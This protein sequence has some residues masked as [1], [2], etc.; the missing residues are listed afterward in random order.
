MKKNK[1]IAFSLLVGLSSFLYAGFSQS[2]NFTTSVDT[3]CGVIIKST[4]SIAFRDEEPKHMGEFRII[5]NIDKRKDVLLKIK[6]IKKSSNIK[7]VNN[8]DIYVYIDRFK[9]IRIKELQNRGIKLKTSNHKMYIYIDKQ[10]D[11]I[12]KGKT[13]VSFEMEVIC[14]S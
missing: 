14:K 13:R 3:T 10:R 2:L 6:N 11:S 5:S 8:S 1:I 4:G 12:Y 7:D 9:K